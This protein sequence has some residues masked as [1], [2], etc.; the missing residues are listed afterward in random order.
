MTR[1]VKKDCGIHFG[2]QPGP[3]SKCS[4]FANLMADPKFRAGL[5]YDGTPWN[6]VLGEIVSMSK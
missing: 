6:A 1:L 4:H 2:P 3:C 5:Q